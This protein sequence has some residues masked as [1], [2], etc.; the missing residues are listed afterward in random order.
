MRFFKALVNGAGDFAMIGKSDYRRDWN[1]CQPPRVEDG[2]VKSTTWSILFDV[3][4]SVKGKATLRLSICGFR[5]PDGIAVTV[6]DHD[7]GNTGPIPEDGVMHRDGIHGVLY[8]RDVSF[9]ASLLKPGTN[10]ITLTPRAK[11]WPDGVL[12]DYVRLEMDD[13]EAK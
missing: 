3:P 10:R 12:Y 13:T 4:E 11:A 8:E 7:A 5:G 1:Y 2:K 9:D 6:N